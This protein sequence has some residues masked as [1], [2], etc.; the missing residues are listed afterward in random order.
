MRRWLGSLVFGLLLLP[1]PGTAQLV[2]SGNI[3][4]RVVDSAGEALPGVAVTTTGVGAA[5]STVTRGDGR[6][7]IPNLSPG[8]YRVRAELAGFSAISRAATVMVGANTEIDFT[9]RPTIDESITV[10]G[11]SPLLDVRKSGTGAN[12]TGIELENVP[13]ARDPWVVLQSVPGILVDRVNVG[14]NESGQQ[15]YFVS[16]GVE[17]HQTEWNLDGVTVTEMQ[18]TGSSGFYYD[19]E[20]FEEFNVTTGGSDPSIKTP[21]AQIN[22]VTR[23]GTNEPRGS[24]RYLFTDHGY[25]ADPTVPPEARDYL[26]QG[27]SID[28]LEELGLEAGGP[29][30]RDRL[31]L[32]GAIARNEI[33]NAVNDGVVPTTL[34]SV[35]AKLNAQLV[36]NNSA[37]LF[38]MWNDKQVEGRGATLNSPLDAARDQ[39]GPGNVF[40]LEDTHVFSPDFYVSGMVGIIDNGFRLEGRGGEV[41]PYWEG[42]SGVDPWDRGWRLNNRFFEQD[43]PQDQVRLDASTFFETGAWSHELKAGFGYRDTPVESWVIWPGNMS[44]GEFYEFDSLAGLSRPGHPVYGAEYTELHAG[45]TV[46]LGDLTLQG[47]LRWDRQRARNEPSSVPANPV[48][49]DIL[50]DGHFPGDERALEWA[51]ISPRLGATYAVGDDRRTLVRAAYNRYVDQLGS[52]DVGPQNPFYNDQV[53]YYY[54]E[55]DNGDKRVQ[56][57]EIL[58][59]YGLYSWYGID[60]N[61]PDASIS[62]SRIDYGMDPTSTDEIILGIEHELVPA[63]TVG[64][65]YTRRIRKDFVWQQYEKTRGAGNFYTSADWELAPDRI[66]GTLPDGRPYS[67]PYWVLREGVEVPVY[68]VLTNRP[69]YEQSYD[70]LELVVTKRM[71]AGW[72][73]RGNVSWHDWTQQVG[74]RGIQDPNRLLQGDG[75][76][77]C[78]GS[79]VASSSGVDGYLNS[80][81]SA[82]LNAVHQ[83]PWELTFGAALTA[84]EGYII[85][86]H[87]R[88]RIDGERKQIL[89]A[90]F[91]AFRLP[92]LFQMD[93]RLAKDFRLGR[94]IGFQLALDLF[95]ATNERNVLWRGY[96]LF[97]DLP[98]G[99]DPDGARV[100][101]IQ[102]PRL[103]RFGGRITW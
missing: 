93:L 63:F 91:D 55:D 58:F 22:M 51:S 34:E 38:Y 100:S 83:F 10:S 39:S 27:N 89:V 80:R 82:A 48:I 12:V 60:P 94:G 30:L 16:K 76:F 1:A 61:D 45:D 2:S 18:A 59:E 97:P 15:S 13:T 35:N 17:R 66:E 49:P 88:E 50:P 40:K 74:P 5:R 11:E 46:L 81:W 33:A 43:V 9:L 52:S 79:V 24:A 86:Y 64:L 84:R 103:W 8:S 75:C 90:D 3:V 65:N 95:N 14:G 4:G 26:E 54:W 67:V 36:E 20:S 19:F 85:G 31:W 92:D 28:R 98:D 77:T 87:R 72:M 99:F 57:E 73:M 29:L 78:D 44:W 41:E 68:S 69:D 32:W 101:R 70:G 96:E 25:Q 42:R 47:G 62:T 37:S 56:R 23:R 7:R 102:S 53:L 21:G 71:S 6:Y